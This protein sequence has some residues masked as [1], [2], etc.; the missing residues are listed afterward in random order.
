MSDA[1]HTGPHHEELTPLRAHADTLG[2]L[3][4]QLRWTVLF[5]AF[6]LSLRPHR[7]MLGAVISGV[8]FGMLAIADVTPRTGPDNLASVVITGAAIAAASLLTSVAVIA[9][10]RSVV[11][12]T[13]GDRS[14]SLRT[15]ALFAFRRAQRGAIAIPLVI[16]AGAVIMVLAATAEF[17]TGSSL[18]GALALAG[19]AGALLVTLGIL[20]QPMI[21]ASIVADDADAIDAVTRVLAYAAAKPGRFLSYWA[22][23]AAA[24]LPAIVIAVLFLTIGASAVGF[25]S[26]DTL[27]LRVMLYLITHPGESIYSMLVPV[28]GAQTQFGAARLWLVFAV[29]GGWLASYASASGALVYLLLRAAVDGADPRDVHDENAQTG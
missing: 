11:L 6:R 9:H 24:S 3:I 26:H 15:S 14:T 25:P 27:A 16:C 4:A 19:G 1:E 13:M 28:Y 17:I 2:S 21:A 20:I 22:L 8:W 23:V 18:A 7:L 29:L 12:D 10:V 5:D